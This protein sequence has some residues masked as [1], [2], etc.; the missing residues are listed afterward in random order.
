MTY[1]VNALS[2]ASFIPPIF[3]Q[4]SFYILHV[5][6]PLKDNGLEWSFWREVL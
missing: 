3:V 5:Y 6:I 4:F 1:N 2:I